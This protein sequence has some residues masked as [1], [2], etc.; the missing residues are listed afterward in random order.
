MTL[1]DS[2]RRVE[3]PGGPRRRG[4]VVTAVGRSEIL[5]RWPTV[6]RAIV[7]AGLHSAH[8]FPMSWR[9]TVVGGLNVFA[10]AEL[11]A[12]PEDLR[13]AQG[14]ADLLTI[15]VAQ[16]GTSDEDELG[17]RVDHALAGRVV[18]EQAKGVLAQR[19]DLDMADAYDALLAR[20][21]RDG[22]TLA[23]SALDVLREAQEA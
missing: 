13:T 5:D 21:L 3:R 19:L 1:Q 4:A 11:D 16:P 23:R 12:A 14:F 20:A 22:S 7:D 2:V 9:G 6:G 8:A 10:R 18:V 17:R 15:V